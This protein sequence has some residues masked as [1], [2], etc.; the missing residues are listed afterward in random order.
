MLRISIQLLMKILGTF[1]GEC[2]V[3]LTFLIAFTLSSS[4]VVIVAADSCRIFS[5]RIMELSGG[6]I[7]I[8]FPSSSFT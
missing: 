4:A 8:L 7:E 1:P 3:Q 5:R 2:F 6:L